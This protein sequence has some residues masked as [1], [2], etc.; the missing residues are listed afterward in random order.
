MTALYEL[1]RD[2][3]E[4]AEKLADLELDEQTIADTLEAL[5]GD[6]EVKAQNVA[7]FIRNLEAT[8]T[9]IKEAEVQMAAR[10]KALENR[11]AR[12]KEYLLTNMQSAGILK[13]ECPY[14][15]LSVRDNPPAVDVYEP[16]QVPTEYLRKT[17]AAELNE[18]CEVT[19]ENEMGVDW[20]TITGP[21]E[22]F[23]FTEAPDKASIKEAIKA[24]QEVPG[25]RLTVGK[26]LEIR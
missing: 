9:S 13:V 24:E 25:C 21:R 23:K 18:S 3:R 20:I 10:R 6:L 14:F 4:A 8:A 19:Y 7:F 17:I 16:A 22:L 1:S 12:V 15:K 26:R 11:A 2:Y 5:A